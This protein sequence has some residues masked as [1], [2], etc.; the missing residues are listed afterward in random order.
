ML[1]SNTFSVNVASNSD[2]IQTINTRLKLQ[3]LFSIYHLFLLIKFGK[4]NLSLFQCKSKRYFIQKLKMRLIF[5][6]IFIA[7]CL[8]IFCFTIGNGLQLQI[9][10]EVLI[11]FRLIHNSLVNGVLS[12]DFGMKP[13]C[14]TQHNQNVWNFKCEKSKLLLSIQDLLGHF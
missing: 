10:N 7:N 2:F 14:V 6:Y 4:S 1:N 5:N 8:L 13:F 12:M 9:K 11:Y 3:I